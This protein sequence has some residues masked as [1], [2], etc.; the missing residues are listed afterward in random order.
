[1]LKK[2]LVGALASLSVAGV[3][4]APVGFTV[5]QSVTQY[6]D[7]DSFFIKDAPE[8]FTALP[9][10]FTLSLDPGTGS[11]FIDL[12]ID[13]GRFGIAGANNSLKQFNAGSAITLAALGSA[14]IN[15]DY[16]YALYDGQVSSGWSSPTAQTYLGFV[17][18]SGQLGYVSA[19]WAIDNINHTATLTLGEGAIESVAGASITVADAAVPEPATLSLLGLG[20]LGAGLLRRRKN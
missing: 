15:D 1:M 3:M 6:L 10:G 19:S 14:T 8:Q 9:G 17:T 20:L 12:V 16:G 11:N 5:N 13:G 18:A 2:I 4:A 7:S